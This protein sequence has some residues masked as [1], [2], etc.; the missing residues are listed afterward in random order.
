MSTRALFGILIAAAMT[1]MTLA[2]ASAVTHDKLAYLTFTGPVQVPGAI[3]NAGTYQFRLTNPDVSRNVLQVRS[4]DGSIV[5]GM[6]NTIP[7]SRTAM[8]RD[9]VVTFRETP[10]GVPAAV[11]TLFYGGENV[12]Y[13]FVYPKGGPIMRVGVAPQPPITYA[14]TPAV[15]EPEVAAPVEP[16]W[17]PEPEIT[18][19]TEPMPEPEPVPPAELP[20][21]ASPLPLAAAGGLTSL[22]VGLGLGWLRRRQG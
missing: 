1:V 2:P 12:G 13:E 16:V 10:A 8:T 7:D 6:F 17:E 21:T 18:V 9:T 3:L 15:E 22:L 5:Y 20:R 19:E 14:R 11:K 4:N